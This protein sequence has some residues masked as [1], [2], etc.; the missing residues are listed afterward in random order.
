MH[1]KWQQASG[2]KISDVYHA[3]LDDYARA[4]LQ[5]LF[6]FNY[7]RGGPSGT[8]P[9]RSELQLR[10]AS[11]KANSKRVVKL[12]EQVTAEAGVNTRIPH[13]E[14]ETIFESTKRKLD[15]P[16]G[17]DSD[18]HRHDRVNFTVPK[19]GRG[20]SPSQSRSILIARN[21]L[22][23]SP[24][25]GKPLSAS[26][27]PKRTSRSPRR[28]GIPM[29]AL[30]LTKS[31]L[32]VVELSC[33]DASE[34]HIE[35]IFV[36][37][38]QHCRGRTNAKRC[39]A[40]IARYRQAVAV[41]TFTGFE[42]QSKTKDPREVQFW[43][44]PNDIL[45]CVL[46]P[47]C[48]SI[49]YYPDI[50]KKWPMK[51]RSSLTQSEVEAFEAS[52]FILYDGDDIRTSAK[53]S[54][55]MGDID[56]SPKPGPSI[57]LPREPQVMASG[58]SILSKAPSSGFHFLSRLDGDKRPTTRDGKTFQFVA[59]PSS[60]HLKKIIDNRS[61]D[62]K[63]LKYVRVPSPGYGVILTVCTPNSVDQKTLYEVCISDYPS[64]SCPNFKFMK[65][66]ANRRRKWLPCKHLYFVLQ[67]HFSCTKED[68]FVH[69]PGWSPNEVKLLLDRAEWLN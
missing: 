28:L 42:R 26:T 11:R 44:C 49:L 5:S 10:L 50:P 58:S 35:R 27:P 45:T 54:E 60:E 56:G 18:S 24:R 39:G 65:S 52:G 15:L 59:Q 34:W 46:G 21:H 53:S 67:E 63:I 14:R 13:L 7:L 3:T 64:C 29:K 12:L 23:Q 40:K 61:I 43:F 41:P 17:D 33:A 30:A 47:P 68:V 37:S 22:S 1:H 9:S 55:C 16:P 66:R 4:A 62:C 8:G 69:C 48:K 20:M 32:P 57:P 36:D 25:L 19:I 2:G 31:G 51:V 6:Y 38:E